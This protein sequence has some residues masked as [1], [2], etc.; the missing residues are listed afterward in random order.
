MFILP[1]ISKFLKKE[2]KQETQLPLYIEDY[3]IINEEAKKKE[4]ETVI[5]IDLF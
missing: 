4:K 5:T 3:P 2:K 1:F